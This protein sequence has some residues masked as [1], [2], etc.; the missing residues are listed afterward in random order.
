M[1][2]EHKPLGPPSFAKPL[3]EYKIGD[4]D[5]F[6]DVWPT[7]FKWKPTIGETIESQSGRTL[8]INDITYKRDGV[9]LI[10]LGR[11]MGG[12]TGIEGAGIGPISVEGGSAVT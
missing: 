8:K 12:S 6:Q 1:I 3:I 10:T 2:T 11:D 4:D 5:Y 9:V 7:S